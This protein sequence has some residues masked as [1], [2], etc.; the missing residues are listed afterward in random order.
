MQEDAELELGAP[1]EY[2]IH[3]NKPR[4]NTSRDGVYKLMIF[5]AEQ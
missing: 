1:R 4:P 5:I 2:Q 3:I